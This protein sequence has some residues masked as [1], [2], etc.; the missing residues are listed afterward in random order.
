MTLSLNIDVISRFCK[1]HFCSVSLRSVCVCVC[2]C[3]CVG[4]VNE[5]LTLS[6]EKLCPSSLSI[7]SVFYMSAPSGGGG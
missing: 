2:V 5:G 1:V 6:R 3:V 7:R 4:R